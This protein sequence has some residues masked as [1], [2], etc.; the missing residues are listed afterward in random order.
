MLSN[1]KRNILNEIKE[2]EIQLEILMKRLHELNLKEQKEKEQK[3]KE[4]NFRKEN[5][6][7]L[8]TPKNITLFVDI[9]KEEINKQKTEKQLDVEKNSSLFLRHKLSEDKKYHPYRTG[10][11]IKE[12]RYIDMFNYILVNN[13]SKKEGKVKFINECFNFNKLKNSLELND[14]NVSKNTQYNKDTKNENNVNIN[15]TKDKIY[16][17]LQKKKIN[18]LKIAARDLKIKGYSTMQKED[19]VKKIYEIIK[20]KE[21]EKE[22]KDKKDKDEKER[23][24]N[25]NKKLT[26]SELLKSCDIDEE[27]DYDEND[28]ND[29]NENDLN[30]NNDDN[31][32]SEEIDYN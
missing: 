7:K 23:E 24:E 6:I 4:Q 9:T 17:A 26:K 21:K 15:K 12:K 1:S 3:E 8:V 14:D 29:L 27:I 18:E 10:S 30:D 32:E 22:E 11:K 31:M 25:K 5:K 13:E 16:I 2:T 19:L 28:L 20:Q